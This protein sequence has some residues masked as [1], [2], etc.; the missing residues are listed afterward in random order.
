M[1]AWGAWGTNYSTYI[2]REPEYRVFN[3]RISHSTDTALRF[4]YPAFL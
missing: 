4:Y 1:I 3:A 2:P